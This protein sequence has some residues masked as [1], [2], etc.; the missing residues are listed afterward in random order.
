MASD[1]FSGYVRHRLQERFGDAGPGFVVPGPPWRDYQ[2]CDLNLSFT[3]ERWKP[4]K[5]SRK[6]GREDGLYGL[7]G[8]SFTSRDRKARA[9]VE[10]ARKSPFG[11]RFSTAEIFFSERPRGGDFYVSLD[12]GRAKRVRTRKRRGKTTS[13]G[14]HL[15]EASDTS[16]T[17][18][19]R[20][21]GNGI[22]HLFGV[23]FERDVAGVVMDTLAINGAR[24]SVQFGWDEAL[25][26]EHIKRRDPD[27]LILAYGTNAVGDRRDPIAR[28]EERFERGVRRLQ[29]MAP[30]ASCVLIGPTDRPDKIVLNDDEE[31]PDVCYQPRPRQAPLISAQRAV[32]RRLGCAYWDMAAAMG[33]EMSMVQWSASEPRLGARDHIHLTRAGYE[34]LAADFYRALMVGYQRAQ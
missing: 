22:V 4:W 10:T 12:G 19:I 14:Y 7:A 28:Y 33:G 5:V 9:V 1:R 15:I 25:Q 16:H 30:R 20:P 11:R 6:I 26:A 24:L 34:K 3:K 2:H 23:A 29:A 17:M 8:V 21:R 31:Q 32:A 13:P 27:L 18:E